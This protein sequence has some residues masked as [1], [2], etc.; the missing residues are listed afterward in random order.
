MCG[1]NFLL[2]R[3]RQTQ[4]AKTGLEEQFAAALAQCAD[5]GRETTQTKTIDLPARDASGREHVAMFGFNRLAINGLDHDSDQPI[6]VTLD[7]VRYTLICNGEIYNY[8]QLADEYG[9]SYTTHSDCESIIHLY[10]YVSRVPAA[11]GGE[12]HYSDLLRLLD[13]VFAFVLSA[14]HAR[15]TSVLV[16]RDRFGVRPL[17]TGHMDGE[18]DSLLV[19]STLKTVTG[20]SCVRDAK[21]FPPG[22]CQMFTVSPACISH[23]LLCQYYSVGSIRALDGVDREAARTMVR[24]ALWSA[25][26]K[27]VANTDRPI[28][29]LLSGGLDSSLIASMVSVALKEKYDDAD[30]RL[31]TYSIGLEGSVDLKYA[32]L[33]AEHIGSDH[34]EV[35]VT[36]EEFLAAIPETIRTIESYDTTSVRA[37]AGNRLIAKY[38]SENSPSGAKVIFNG[39]GSDEVAGGYLYFSK[40]PT[41]GVFDAECKRLLSTIHFFDVLRSDRS[42]AS[43]NLEARTPFLDA[44]FVQ[45]YLSTSI[46]SRRNGME[47]QLLREAMNINV[48][49]DLSGGGGERCAL[50]PA[51]VLWRRKEAFSDGVSGMERSWTDIIKERLCDIPEYEEHKDL[52]AEIAEQNFAAGLTPEQLFYRAVFRARFGREREHVIPGYWMPKFV[53][54]SD[55]SAR[56]L[57]LYGGT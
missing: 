49:P 30:H 39:D 48:T 18:P 25:V 57:A 10:H 4:T 24:S 33:V 27:R 28:A 2:A 31:E 5:R 45:A 43:N 20:Y 53:E 9:F 51:E 54:A 7:G 8:R 23:G 37:S 55:A 26:R 17:F 16:G 3:T 22:H 34:H 44:G 40:A 41:P 47:K 6:Q 29:C 12:F 1:I 15:H 13:G 14:E 52:M 38:I 19:G 35:V 21:Q 11:K 36:E 46:D 32:R 50:L 56:T 42:I